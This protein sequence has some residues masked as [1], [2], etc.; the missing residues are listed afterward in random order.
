MKEEGQL[1]EIE[2]VAPREEK[3]VSFGLATKRFESTYSRPVIDE[4]GNLPEIFLAEV[5]S[6][7]RS[8]PDQESARIIMETKVIQNL[9]YSYFS[10]VKKNIADLVPKTI[11][12]LLI[13]ES[14]RMAQS[15]LV[16]RVYQADDVENL[17]VE[18][19][20]VAANREA[21]QQVI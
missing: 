5:P 15:E 8:H 1:I 13:R 11:M 9:I 17:L 2:E 19:P 10:I 20:I 12:A 3:K 4:N 16:V 7:L 6:K 21:C 18:D 14:A